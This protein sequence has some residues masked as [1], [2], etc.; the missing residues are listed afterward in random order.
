IK[1]YEVGYL[2]T[3]H[4]VISIIDVDHLD[5][6]C[7]GAS[8]KSSKDAAIHHCIGEAATLFED[9]I[10]LRA[11]RAPTAAARSKILSLR[12]RKFSQDR[13]RYFSSLLS[14]KGDNFTTLKNALEIYAFRVSNNIVASRAST[15]GL[16]TPRRF[17]NSLYN[18]PVMPLF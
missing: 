12:D 4:L 3:R 8:L 7:M 6:F 9:A 14:T 13:R 1:L 11:G 16:L 18:I 15:T 5:F 2:K 17:H 10:R